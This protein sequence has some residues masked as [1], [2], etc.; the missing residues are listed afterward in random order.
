MVELLEV[1]FNF[2]DSTYTPPSLTGGV[3]NFTHGLGSVSIG[4]LNQVYTDQTYIYT[5]TSTGLFIYDLSESAVVAFTTYSGGFTTIGGNSEG[6]YLGTTTSGIRYMDKTCISGTSSSVQD[7]AVYLADLHTPNITSSGIKYLSAKDNHL[8]VCTTA[9]I[10]HFR[11]N[12]NPFIHS[13]TLI[14]GSQKCFITDSA[15]YY[16]VSGTNTTTSGMEYSLNRVDMCLTDWIT[17]HASY[18][19]GSGIFGAGLKLTDMYIT[20]ASAERGGN[21]IFCTTSSGI[22][23]IDEDSKNYAIYY[24]R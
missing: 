14:S 9:G 19:T 23:V 1:I 20:E 12:L 17:P 16:T 22:Y 10:D 11:Y 13:K 8:L 24:T 2:T 3:Y 5:A 15:M 18:T 6:V 7:L 4:Y 21:T